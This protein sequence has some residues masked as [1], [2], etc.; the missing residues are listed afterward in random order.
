MWGRVYQEVDTSKIPSGICICPVSN[1]E[2]H[3]LVSRN[4]DPVYLS[5]P[6]GGGDGDSCRELASPGVSQALLACVHL[7]SDFFF[8]VRGGCT[9]AEALF[10]S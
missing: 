2:R 3:R 7:L 4:F 1:P 8:E 5:S 6:R 9:Q 10:D